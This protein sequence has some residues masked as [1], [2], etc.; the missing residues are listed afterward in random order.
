MESCRTEWDSLIS[1]AK[2]AVFAVPVSNLVPV[3]NSQ[4][5]PRHP[6]VTMCVV[7][8][9][10]RTRQE[11]TADVCAEVVQSPSMLVRDRMRSP[12]RGTITPAHVHSPM[13]PPPPA[14]DAA[15]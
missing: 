9:P 4:C 7:L 3:E 11:R 12:Y 10:S 14:L 8:E 13:A 5:H 2:A 15:N 6:E 1:A